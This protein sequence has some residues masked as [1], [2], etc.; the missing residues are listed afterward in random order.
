M[1][2]FNAGTSPIHKQL[3]QT[4]VPHI[5]HWSKDQQ[6]TLAEEEREQRRKRRRCLLD[7]FVREEEKAWE[8]VGAETTVS[9]SETIDD[10]FPGM[11][12]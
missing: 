2:Y 8:T 5:F 7:E 9:T 12:C 4:A 6:P 1:Y 3:K 11:Y 10:V